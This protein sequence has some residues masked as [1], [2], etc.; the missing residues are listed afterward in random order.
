VSAA[1]NTGLEAAR[2]ELI[3]RFDA[4]DVCYPQRLQKQVDFMRQNPD[5]VLIGSDA[6][7]MSEEGEYLFTYRNIGHTNE[8]IQQRI[9]IYCPFVHSTVCYRKKAV[10]EEGGYEVNAHTFEDYFLWTRLVKKGKVCNFK[11]PLIK[12]R[13]NPDSVTVD[14]KDRE[15][16]FRDIK[17]KA[18][19]SGVITAEEG[20][21]LLGSIRKMDRKKKESSYHRMLGKK[22]LWN[23][24]K[25]GRSRSH[26]FKAMVREPFN[27]STYML[28][29][30]SF[31]P[32][33]L[34]EKIYT[35]SKK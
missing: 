27:I 12:V 2:G 13:F 21:I 4:D 5:Y 22:F 31:L 7:Y 23:N 11:E 9:A 15:Q 34:I 20:R 3:V 16:V 1:L 17:K 35:S 26:L 19:L 25:P 33:G 18:L 6:D 10:V 30:L 29:A 28:L 32:K 24:Y 14:E 8:E